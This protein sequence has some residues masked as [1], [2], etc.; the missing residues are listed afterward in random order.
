[1]DANVYESN[2]CPSATLAANNTFPDP[3]GPTLL[4]V[5]HILSVKP[6]KSLP[7]RFP[8]TNST[9]YCLSILGGADWT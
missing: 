6:G 9:K 5:R 4:I 8:S 1:M 3:T 2:F 7:G